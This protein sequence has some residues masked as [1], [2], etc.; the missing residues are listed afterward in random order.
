MVRMRDDSKLPLLKCSVSGLLDV[1]EQLV[2][3]GVRHAAH[4]ARELIHLPPGLPPP[5]APCLAVP[6]PPAL[7]AALA[8]AAAALAAALCLAEVIDP[9]PCAALG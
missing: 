9:A 3:A 1:L 6:R 7:A 4:L 5:P 8:A 2:A